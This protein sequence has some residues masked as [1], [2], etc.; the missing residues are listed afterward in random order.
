MPT[1]SING[2]HI[3]LG[4]TG[5]IAAYKAAELVRRLREGGAEVR[6]VMTKNAEAF[7]SSLTLQAVSGH[8][9]RSEMFDASAE[10]GM[11]HIELARWADVI[12]VAP[13]SAGF[14][15]RLAHGFADDLLT[16][17]CLATE[18]RIAIAP[19][20]N[21][22]MWQ[23]LATEDNV[24]TLEDRGVSVFGPDAGD[25]ACGETGPGR[26]SQPDAIVAD[27]DEL[28]GSG[29]LAGQHVLV[30]AGSTWEA[31]DPVRGLTNQ[32][33]GKMG[34]AVAN[35][36]A[37]AGASVTLVSGPATESLPK[38]LTKVVQVTSARQML[39]A[40]LEHLN[41]Q[42]IFIAVA[43]VADYRPAT[44][45]QQKMKKH[46]EQLTLQFVRNPDILAE[47][48]NQV[49]DIFTVGFAAET[50]NLVSEA[51]KKLLAKRADLIA[52]NLV[53]GEANALGS[54]FNSLQLIDRS[55]VTALGPAL[56]TRIAVELI[57]EISTRFHARGT[58][59]NTR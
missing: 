20:M 2:K 55:G 24:Q 21:R 34:Y 48:K 43:A 51:R 4:V 26:M 56:K 22:V 58:L 54:D 45:A 1:N 28:L 57:E 11:S 59:Q 33:S 44:Q 12:V 31:I 27:L 16:T 10:A 32:S 9:V 14:I 36:A 13:A 7:I 50:D 30:T 40:V 47:V 42:Q 29:A 23:S 49:P 6:V 3:V 25:Q 5:G 8:S 19:A 38:S 39:D 17:L 35:A 15:A 37:Q 53:S 52:A 46:D 18:A 41:G